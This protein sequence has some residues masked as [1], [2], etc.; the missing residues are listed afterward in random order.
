LT[1]LI[2]RRF[3]KPGRRAVVRVKTNGTDIVFEDV[4]LMM[5]RCQIHMNGGAQGRR[6]W[7]DG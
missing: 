6:R 1:G 3:Y 7:G 4:D 2:I 5:E